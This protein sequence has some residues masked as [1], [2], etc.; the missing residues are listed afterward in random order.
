[1]LKLKKNYT[2][3]TDGRFNVQTDPNYR[4]A[5]FLKISFLDKMNKDSN[6]H[7]SSKIRRQE[8]CNMYRV[9]T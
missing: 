5:S 1:M 7:K 3:Q 4:K 8:H 2:F 9:R 6:I